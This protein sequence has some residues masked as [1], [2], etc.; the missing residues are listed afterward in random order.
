[1]SNL[2][3]LSNDQQFTA[4]ADFLV[5]FY[6]T[7]R[8]FYICLFYSANKKFKEAVGFCFKVDTYLKQLDGELPTLKKSP[9][10]ELDAAR[11]EGIESDLKKLRGELNESKYKLQTAS[12]MDDSAVETDEKDTLVDKNKLQKVPLSERWDI[13][14]ED[15]SLLSGNPNIVKMPPNYEPIPCKPLF[16]DLALNYVELPS[17]EDKIDKKPQA[18]GKTGVKGLFKGFFG[19]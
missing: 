1:M 2:P 16:F 18:E 9:R 5:L 13:Y 15:S 8:A 3:G 17:L 10:G 6:K 7:L 14:F 12:I 4:D 11:L 19:L